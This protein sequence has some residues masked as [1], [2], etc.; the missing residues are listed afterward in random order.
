MPADVRPLST[1]PIRMRALPEPF[2]V[3]SLTLRRYDRYRYS[4]TGVR[5]AAP[6]EITVTVGTTAI[7]GASF[8]AVRPN[9]EM[10][11]FDIILTSLA[12]VSGRRRRRADTGTF[13]PE[14]ITT[15]SRPA[16]TAPHITIN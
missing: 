4:V 10:P 14:G 13:T 8:I 9:P 7:T 1:S 5:F 6:A 3:T 12:G 11:G 16:D 2:S 15:V